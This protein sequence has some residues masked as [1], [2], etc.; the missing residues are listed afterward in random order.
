MD[1]HIHPPDN[2]EGGLLAGLG[3]L[4]LVEADE[5]ESEAIL[6]LDF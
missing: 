4:D 3:A 2:A 6:E 5:V 1:L